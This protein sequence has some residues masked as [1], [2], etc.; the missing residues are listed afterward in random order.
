MRVREANAQGVNSTSKNWDV[1]GWNERPG[2]GAQ[3]WASAYKEVGEE[4]KSGLGL[5]SFADIYDPAAVWIVS[6]KVHLFS[7]RRVGQVLPAKCRKA[8]SHF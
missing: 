7:H 2:Q 1:P 5:T 6:G 3:V 8:V 4:Q